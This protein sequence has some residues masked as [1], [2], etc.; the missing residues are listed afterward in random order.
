M[1]SMATQTPGEEKSGNG[2]RFND[3]LATVVARG[4]DVM[5][6]MHLTRGGFHRGGRIGQKIVRTMHAPLGRRL[7]I[8]LNGHVLTPENPKL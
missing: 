4:A 3:L 7:L 8:L 2:F 1:Q 5:A 6:Q